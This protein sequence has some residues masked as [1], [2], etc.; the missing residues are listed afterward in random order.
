MLGS[1]QNIAMPN[2]VLNTAVAE[3][4]RQFADELEGAEDLRT[5][6]AALLKKTFAEHRRI[7]FDGNGYSLEWEHEAERRGLLNLKTSVAAFKRYNDEKN[8]KLFSDHGVMSATEINSRRGIL[9]E[10]YSKIVNI[11]ALTMIEMVSRD[12]IPAVSAYIGELS[13]T[14]AARLAA[15]PEANSDVER[16]LITKLSAMNAKA[17]AKLE[18]LKSAEK[19]ATSQEGYEAKAEVYESRVL[20]L[21]S[22]LRTVVDAL[23]TMTA[24][25]Y[26]PLPT[27]GELMFCV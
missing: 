22:E 9:F 3:S 16:D 23:E 10:N 13:S 12:I 11:E 8:I 17:Y 5:A 26:W 24:T 2:I 19:L 14:M 21:M 6:I 4:F 25:E 15:V 18:E 7:I 27:Y 1:S 20:P